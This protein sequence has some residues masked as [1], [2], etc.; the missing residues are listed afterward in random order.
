MTKFSG[1]SASCVCF[2]TA[3]YFFTILFSSVSSY[4]IPASGDSAHNAAS[5]V[6]CKF[7]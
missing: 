7:F 6:T 3:V 4:F 5:S 2:T 1:Y